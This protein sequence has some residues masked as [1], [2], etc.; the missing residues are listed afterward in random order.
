MDQRKIKS[1]RGLI[2]FAAAAVLAVIYSKE[3]VGLV[4]FLLMCLKPFFIGCAIAFVINI[5]MKRVESLLFSK[6]KS[7]L[8]SRLRRPL[9][10]LISVILLLGIIVLVFA[11]VVPQIGR[12]LTEIGKQIPDFLEELFY[13]MENELGAYPEIMKEVHRLEQVKFDWNAILASIGSF[14]KNGLG[15][16]INSTVA[17]AGNIVGGVVN[18]VV[19]FI[20][21]FYILAQKERLGHQCERLLHAYCKESV[22]LRV[23]KVCSLLNRNFSNFITG[24]CV[25][26]VILGG[27]FVI[28]M[29]VFR[30]PYPLLIGVIIGFLALIPIV[31]AFAGCA[32]G[33][34]LIFMY[35]PVKAFWFLILFLILQQ[36][37]GNLIY[38]HVV[39]SSVGLPS[40]WVLVAVTAGGSLMGVLGILLFIPL[41]S[42]VYALLKEDVARRNKIKEQIM[43]KKEKDEI[44][45]KK[46]AEKG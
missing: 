14:M 28:T 40:I 11:L 45:G 24:Q 2:I 33:V 26:A 10:I 16:V 44:K 15:S 13:W 37:E 23:R 9:S 29:A 12:A 41:T 1:I 38:P 31:G 7:K 42:T 36:I 19:A 18:T 25:E 20:F 8:M 21:A 34:F 17:V 22:Y 4:S 6:T 30:F 46:S 27:L 39:G 5:L 3:A 43:T 35:S 32:V